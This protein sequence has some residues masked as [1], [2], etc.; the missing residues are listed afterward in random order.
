[1]FGDPILNPITTMIDATNF[2]NQNCQNT[3]TELVLI[4]VVLYLRG[5]I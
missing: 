4:I 5:A 3:I 2:I 1:M